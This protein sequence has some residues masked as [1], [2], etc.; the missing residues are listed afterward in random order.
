MYGNR[1]GRPGSFR[2]RAHGRHERP[3]ST[4]TSTA[5][6]RFPATPTSVGQARRFL[7][8]RAARRQSGRGADE[9]VLML[10][11]LVDQRSPARRHRVRGGRPRGSRP[12]LAC[13]SRSATR[14]TGFPTPPEQVPDAP[15][16]AGLAHC[17]HAGRRLGH[18]DA[19]RPARQD[20]VVHHAVVRCGRG[21]V[22]CG[23][24][25]RSSAT[26]VAS[27][28]AAGCRLARRCRRA[29]AATCRAAAA[30]A[31]AT[32]RRTR[33]AGLARPGRAGGARRAARRGRGHRR[34]GASSVTSTRR[35]KTSWDG[36]TASLVGRSVYDLVPDSLTPAMGRRLRRVHPLAGP[37]PRRAPTRRR[38]QTRRRDRR[39]HGA[40]HQHLRPPA[41][42]PG[43]RRHPPGPG[44]EEAAALV[45]AD[46]RVARDPRRRPDRRTSGRTASSR[47]SAGAS[48][49]T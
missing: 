31:N 10:S 30:A 42:R 46:E 4:L 33:G 9:L 40:G 1:Y 34:A 35:P 19:A 7:L 6:R 32:G 44:R 48:T 11:E 8:G 37:G 25:S 20:R 2:G 23:T 38:H 28:T 22:G 21:A 49:G 17:A 14:P 41:R 36:R 24:R 16:R 18:R 29:A 12:P 3:S 47:P 27:T 13:A 26:R 43:C 39:R 45:G 5:T 15:R